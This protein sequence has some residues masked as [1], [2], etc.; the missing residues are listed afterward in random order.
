MPEREMKDW[1][2]RYRAGRISRREFVERASAA[3]FGLLATEAVLASVDGKKMPAHSHDHQDHEHDPNQTNVNPYTEWRKG[4]GIPIVTDYS[5][6]NLRAV[7]V[8]P[9]KRMNA[10]GAYIDLKGGEGVNDGY[11]CEIA[12]QAKTSSQRYLF[13]EVIYI[14][15]GEGETIIRSGNHSQT[16]KWKAGSVVGPPLNAWRQHVNTG[17]QPARF[18]AITNAPV[19]I[20]LFHS[21]DFVF[22]NDYIFR[23]RYNGDPSYFGGGSDK[24]RHKQTSAEESEQ[25]GGVY[26]WDSGFVPD[27]R[28]IGLKVSKERG[29]AN[30]RIEL[31][32]SDNTMQAHI[33]EFEV[34]TYKKAHRHGPGSHV[35]ML[36][37]TGY[38]LMW[39][40]SPK[41]SDAPDHVR[42]DFTEASLFVPPDG[43]FHQHF[44]TGRD[45]ARYL[46]ATWGG[47]GKWFMRALGGGGRT[48]RLGKTSIR[49]G[50][51]L[52][53]YE[54][55]DPAIRE[56][57][58][59]ELRKN[60][61]ESRMKPKG[62]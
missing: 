33:S 50:G 61:V 16:L 4:E 19:V 21:T 26:T 32:L 23:D 37:G 46:A 45:P 12:P 47:D 28:A 36:N 31:Q 27:A 20:D 10:S 59:A 15:S 17:N 11:V 25:S 2:G 56:I 29:A 22:N 34:G 57:F 40:G 30:S 43:W 24:L 51:N 60:G 62:A 35:V 9:W 18:L 55:E 48:H 8:K 1:I 41:F 53:E 38:T 54:D 49:K 52:I 3:G 6:A 39:K 7:D 13:E 44:N 5:I 42:V 14:L 58:E